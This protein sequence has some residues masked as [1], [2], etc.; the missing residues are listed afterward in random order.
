VLLVLLILPSGL[1]GL[2]VR[3]RDVGVRLLVRESPPPNET[4]A[5]VSV[6]PAA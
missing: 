2:W 5:P 6:E 4:P 1:G 3:L